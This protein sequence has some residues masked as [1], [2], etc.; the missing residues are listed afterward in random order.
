MHTLITF[1]KIMH[2]I[3]NKQHPKTSASTSQRYLLNTIVPLVLLLPLCFL[4]CSS[5]PQN[6]NNLSF[7]RTLRS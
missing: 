2:T 6:S 7:I 4:P 5:E 1:N 3:W